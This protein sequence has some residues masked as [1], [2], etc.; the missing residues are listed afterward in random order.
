[1]QPLCA[2]PHSSANGSKCKLNVVDDTKVHPTSATHGNKPSGA[3]SQ[4]WLVSQP[5]PA[6]NRSSSSQLLPPGGVGAII[7]CMCV[8]EASNL[9]KGLL[10]LS[11]SRI[12][13]ALS[14]VWDT[15]RSCGHNS[16][17]VL[18][19]SSA[20]SQRLC[21]ESKLDK[22]KNEWQTFHV[23]RETVWHRSPTM[24]TLH[25]VHICELCLFVDVDGWAVLRFCSQYTYHVCKI[26]AKCLLQ[27][28]HSIM[29]VRESVT[30]NNQDCTIDIH[31]T[32]SIVY[33]C[34]KL[35]FVQ[36]GRLM[37][38]VRGYGGIF[39]Q[40]SS[41]HNYRC[42]RLEDQLHNYQCILVLFMATAA[43]QYYSVGHSRSNVGPSKMKGRESLGQRLQC[44]LDSSL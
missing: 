12:C 26:P 44:K 22:E 21:E 42:L 43:V 1:M 41:Y 31:T 16:G 3:P 37:R 25:S 34:T 24:T 36:H 8:G 19:P 28:P 4:A 40:Q 35:N 13:T 9:C 17:R 5:S 27:S 14:K 6:H 15:S 30:E 33:V 11:P 29:F 7:W 39:C 2:I 18:F 23:T 20:C 10:T 38:N 32:R